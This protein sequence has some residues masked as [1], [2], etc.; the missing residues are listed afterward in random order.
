ML[1]VNDGL[2]DIV[3]FLLEVGADP[4]IHVW[5]I[6]SCLVSDFRSSNT[7]ALCISDGWVNNTVVTKSLRVWAISAL[8]QDLL[9]CSSVFRAISHKFLTCDVPWPLI[10]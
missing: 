10:A 1:A 9:C 5:V 8:F 2:T 7:V 6:M 3:N 4:N